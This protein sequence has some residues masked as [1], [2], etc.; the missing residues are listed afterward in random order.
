L[1]QA[2]SFRKVN[3]TQGTKAATGDGR[4][5]G[6]ITVGQAKRKTP[7]RNIKGRGQDTFAQHKN[8]GD[9][10]AAEEFPKFCREGL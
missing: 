7:S 8:L 3:A 2:R 9:E 5:G 4:T 10:R 6:S 1:L